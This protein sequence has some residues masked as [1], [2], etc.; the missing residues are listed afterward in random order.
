MTSAV[1]NITFDCR[2]AEAVA[3]FWGEVTGHAVTFREQPGNDH[4]VVAPPEGRWPRLLFIAVPEGKAVKNRV[5]LDI[6]P[7]DLTQAREVERLSALG[8]TIVDDRRE[9]EPG[10]WVVMGDPEG[11]EF[12]VEYA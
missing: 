6:V 11:N 10:G 5:H 3:R 7:G 1:A 2:D 9:A 12:C 8:A 4:W